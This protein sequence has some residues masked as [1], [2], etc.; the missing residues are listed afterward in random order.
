MVIQQIC[1]VP[2]PLSKCNINGV[3]V[4]FNG[5]EEKKDLQLLLVVAKRNL[6]IEMLHSGETA[7]NSPVRP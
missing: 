1:P 4:P 6:L 2:N 3:T 7:D 5:K